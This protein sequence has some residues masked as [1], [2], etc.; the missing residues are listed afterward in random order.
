MN[1]AH[2]ASVSWVERVIEELE[3]GDLLTYNKDQHVHLIPTRYKNIESCV[4]VN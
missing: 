2:V 3:T 1:I 4:G